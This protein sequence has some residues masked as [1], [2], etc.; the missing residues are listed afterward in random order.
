MNSFCSLAFILLFLPGS[1]ALWAL[2]PRR[3]RPAVLL[4]ASYA[5]FWLIS[6]ALLGMLVAATLVTYAT[7]L[8]LGALRERQRRAL[9]GLSRAERKALKQRGR[10]RLNLVLA[11]GAL[12]LLGM[13]VAVKYLP[14]FAQIGSSL[15]ELT[16][17]GG[18]LVAPRLAAPIGIS[19]YTLQALSYLFDV[20]NGVVAADRNLLRLALFMSFFPEIM[21]GPICRYADTADQLTSGRPPQGSEVGSGCVRILWGA[22]KILLVADRVNL[23]VKPVFADHTAWD[24]TVI[25]VAAALYTLQLY[26]DFS[27]TMDIALGAA[28]LFGI[29]L[30]EN[31]RQP[32]FSRTASE[33]WERW[34]ITLGSWLRDYV[35]YPV[36]LS[37]PVKG[38]VGVLRKRLGMRLGSV[39]SGGVALACVWVL[40]GLWHGAGWQYLFFG[41]YYFALILGASLAEPVLQRLRTLLHVNPEARG[42]H[43]FQVVRTCLIVIIGELFFRA[44]GLRAG[45]AM[46]S[47]VVKSFSPAQL[48][49]GTLLAPGMD[50][51]DFALTAV[52]VLV[53]LAVDLWREHG[54]PVPAGA[55]RHRTALTCVAGVGLVLAVIVF[56]A[57]GGT[58][59][60]LDPIY[61]QF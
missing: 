45:L 28:H 55:L 51:A 53:L 27:G 38:V 14:F 54:S 34:H 7:G 33:F 44:E 16:G 12:V 11:T 46:F 10:A 2:A 20:K 21:E 60:P 59:V 43:L 36:S 52:M 26:C 18:P 56:G 29:R 1:A 49:D 39:L 13:L 37:G 3:A 30:P 40:N 19:F 23:F 32:F 47:T 25:F 61:A 8:A 15:L 5:C 6:G 4:A 57:Y 35:F 22:A 42:W 50:G 24:G 9:V 41:L 31:F 48:A 58:Y 17:L